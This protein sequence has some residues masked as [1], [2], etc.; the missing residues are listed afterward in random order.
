VT[1][2]RKSPER[3]PSTAIPVDTVEEITYRLYLLRLEPP[4]TPEQSRALTRR[5]AAGK[6]TASD[7]INRRNSKCYLPIVRAT[8]RVLV[9]LGMVTP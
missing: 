3:H 1:S 8:L 5:D 7:E 2:E 6:V 4:M 9:D